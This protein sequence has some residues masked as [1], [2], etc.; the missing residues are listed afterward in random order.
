MKRKKKKTQTKTG[1]LCEYVFTVIP[2][3]GYRGFSDSPQQLTMIYPML[4]QELGSAS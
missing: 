4:Y 2:G 3:V 1:V